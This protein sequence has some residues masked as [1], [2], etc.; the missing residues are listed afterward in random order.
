[1]NDDEPILLHEGD[2]MI[3]LLESAAPAESGF[4]AAEARLVERLREAGEDPGRVDWV[5]VRRRLKRAAL[6]LVAAGAL[7]PVTAN[8]FRLTARGRQ[9]LD[10]KAW[11]IDETV[12]MRFP[13]YREFVEARGGTGPADDPRQEAFVQGMQAFEAGLALTDNPWP[14]DTV[15]HLAWENGWFAAR[16]RHHGR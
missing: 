9:L 13:E 16:D 3:A 6:Q 15:D 2:L 4:E 8:R 1:M 5:E 12:L 7:E 10:E 14:F 11:G